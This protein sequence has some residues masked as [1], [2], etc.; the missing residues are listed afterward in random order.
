MPMMSNV[1][2]VHCGNGFLVLN[3]QRDK[4]TRKEKTK[5]PKI[6]KNSG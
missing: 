5:I 3:P 4:I 1:A 2:S 6:S